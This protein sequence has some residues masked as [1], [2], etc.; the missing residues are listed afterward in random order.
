MTDRVCLRGCM[1]RGDH[2][3][4][5]PSYNDPTH[6]C[7][8]CVPREAWGESLLCGV[9]FGRMRA[10][11]ADTR[12]LLGRLRAIADPTKATPL[13]QVRVASS[14][15]EPSAPVGADIL[16]AIGTVEQAADWA[17]VDLAAYTNDHSTVTYLC[18][19]ILNR[20][21]ETDGIRHAWS[22]QDAVDRWGVERRDRNPQPWD[23]DEEDGETVLGGVPELDVLLASPDAA[24]HARVT[25][26]TLRRWVQAGALEPRARLR[27][28]RR[29]T[30]YY[31]R[32]EVEAAATQA[33]T[34]R[35][36]P[37]PERVG[38]ALARK[39]GIDA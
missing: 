20:H 29:V 14:S 10:L 19:L 5:C 8:G 22:V 36:A 23:D 35:H 1:R 13:D 18:A 39:Y 32:S 15:T 17:F 9:C 24:K 16:D 12:D 33:D 26:S 27:E 34:A 25:E 30:A 37:R 6:E 7:R 2:Y 31:Y 11:L 4:A 21:P 38:P 3:A 28:G